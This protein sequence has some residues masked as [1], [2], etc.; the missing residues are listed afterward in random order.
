MCPDSRHPAAPQAGT[1]ARLGVRCAGSPTPSVPTALGDMVLI[2]L[3]YYRT[4]LG[5]RVPGRDYV[6]PNNAVQERVDPS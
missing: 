6:T 5:K 3:M 2:A 1:I 4:Y